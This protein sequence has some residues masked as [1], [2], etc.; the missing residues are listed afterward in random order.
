[1]VEFERDIWVVKCAA[2][3]RRDAI[4]FHRKPTLDHPGVARTIETAVWWTL[5]ITKAL[6]D[7]IPIL[8]H[9]HPRRSEAQS[10]DLLAHVQYK[11]PDR[12]PPSGIVCL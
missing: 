8:N 2:L 3:L 1:M 5:G 12:L 6:P 4:G 11:V 10:G 7:K 9:R